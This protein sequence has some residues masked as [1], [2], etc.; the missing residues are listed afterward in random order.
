MGVVFQ[1]RSSHCITP[2]S[3]ASEDTLTMRAPGP[4][5]FTRGIT[6]LVSRKWPRWFVPICISKP[7]SVLVN[8]QVITPALLI[9][10]SIFSKELLS[11]SAHSL[12]LFRLARSH[13]WTITSPP[14][15][16]LISSA[17]LSS[18]NIA[19]EHHHLGAPPAHVK[20]GKLADASVAP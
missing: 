13:L 20:G 15:S 9:R 6:R 14:V 17:S 4:A 12:T 18:L 11:C 2:D 16:F 10:M 5:F 1:L 3:C 8:G 7:S 19:A